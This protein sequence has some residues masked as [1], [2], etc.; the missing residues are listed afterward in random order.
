[1]IIKCSN[2][3]SDFD[4]KYS[5]NVFKMY[6]THFCNKTCR[7]S[8]RKK[9]LNKEDKRYRL[10][11][12]VKHRATVVKEIEFNLK[13]LDIP[14][15]PDFCPILGIEIKKDNRVVADNSP[16]LDRIDPKKGYIKGNI[17]IISNRANRI[18][19]DANYKELYLVYK[20]LKK[21]QNKK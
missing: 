6:S 18:K 2:C 9:K 10:W 7:Y 13:P 19:S 12:N 14:N 8:F 21:I 17:R 15:I 16:S 5:K 20:D 3:R 1:M 4:Y 11:A